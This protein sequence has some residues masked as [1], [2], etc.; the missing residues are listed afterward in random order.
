M[1]IEEIL[2]QP[3]PVLREVQHYLAYLVANQQGGSVQVSG[4]GRNTWPNDYFEQTAG[5]FA[6]ERFERSPQLPF[7]KREYW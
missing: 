1:L 4:S 2:K 3:E 5:A 7:E 6:E